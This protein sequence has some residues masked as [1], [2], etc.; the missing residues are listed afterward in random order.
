LNF[1]RYPTIYLLV[2]IL[3]A[4]M[5][6]GCNRGQAQPAQDE[7]QSIRE[8]KP[9]FTPIANAGQAEAAAVNEAL[10][11]PVVSAGDPAG[12]ADAPNAAPPAVAAPTGAR[13]IISD[14]LVNLRSGPGLDFEVVVVAERGEEYDI[15]GRSSDGE[16]WQICCTAEGVTAWVINNL[17]DTDGPVENV[18]G[19]GADQAAVVQE[20]GPGSVSVR[21]NIPLLN[22]RSEPNTSS[23]VVEIVEAGQEFDV[24]A[25]SEAR[26]WW[27][28]CCV[29]GQEVWLADEFVDLNGPAG[30]VP[31]F[32]QEAAAAAVQPESF[33][34]DLVSQEQFAENG[35]V[36]VFLFVTDANDAAL[37]GYRA[38]ITKDGAEQIAEELSFG[39]QPGFTWPFQDAR[40][41]AQ[42]WKAEFPNTSAAGRWEIQLVDQAGV[43]V[44]PVA[45]FELSPNDANQE[46]YVRYERK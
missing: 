30:I 13:A 26:D 17:V 20:F 36:R 32:G 16:W 40:Q 34:F 21:V 42:N 11:A 8:P 10:A 18:P 3:L 29:E 37:A 46:L 25:A 35:I 44:G 33:I 5:L 1:Q 31:I 45:I 14:P 15:T 38:R 6:A 9:T 7:I 12:Q 41:R 19:V 43:P 27:W 39:G 23:E 22:A 28:V 4:L 24:L 2:L